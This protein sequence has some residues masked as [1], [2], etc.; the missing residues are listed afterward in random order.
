MEMQGLSR[1]CEE[2][3]RQNFEINRKAAQAKELTEDLDDLRQERDRLEKSV[4]EITSYPFL[5][6]KSGEPSAAHRAVALEAKLREL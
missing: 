5:K 1:E 2:L 4:R 6:N 3:E